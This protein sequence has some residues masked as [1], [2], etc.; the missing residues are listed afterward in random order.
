MSDEL[1]NITKFFGDW[2]LARIYQGFSARFHLADWHRTIDEKLKTLDDLYQLM[3][4]ERSSALD[5]HARDGDGG[6]VP[7]R[8][9]A[10]GAEPQNAGALSGFGAYLSNPVIL[11]ENAAALC[12][13]VSS[14][15][16]A[17]IIIA[18]E[19]LLPQA[20]E[21][22]NTIFRPEARSRL[23]QAPVHGS[24]QHADAAGAHGR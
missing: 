22:Y 24:L 11:A 16:Q 8:R 10:A 4:A 17:D 13:E 19:K 7:H 21:L 1:S 14:V 5:A 9:R 20:V 3:Q 15:A 23:L 6:A 18:D 2:H 12:V